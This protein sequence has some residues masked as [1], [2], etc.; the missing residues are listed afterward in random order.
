MKNYA[1]DLDDKKIKEIIICNTVGDHKVEPCGKSLYNDL[2]CYKSCTTIWSED[3]PNYLLMEFTKLDSQGRGV[4][5]RQEY[6][7]CLDYLWGN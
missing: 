4:L 3:Y 6:L 7:Q 2:P 1:Q 5:S